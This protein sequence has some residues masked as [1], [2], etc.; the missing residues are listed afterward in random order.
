MYFTCAD[1]SSQSPSSVSRMRRYDD[2]DDDVSSS[3]SFLLKRCCCCFPI[4]LFKV[5]SHRRRRLENQ[6]RFGDFKDDD[7]DDENVEIRRGFFERRRSFCALVRIVVKF[8]MSSD[9]FSL[10]TITILFGTTTT[11]T[12]TYLGWYGT[13][14]MCYILRTWWYSSIFV[15]FA[16]SRKSGRTLL[17]E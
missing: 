1:W 15:F 17:P 6:P 3:S 13:N 9:A 8:V 7:D 10:L 11:I 14:K 5:A 12:T 4:P 2:D 16:V